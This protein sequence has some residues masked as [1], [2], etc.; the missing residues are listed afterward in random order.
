VKVITSSTASP[1]IWCALSAAP[2]ARAAA[3]TG[4]SLCPQLATTCPQPNSQALDLVRMIEPPSSRA[5]RPTLPGA[6]PALPLPR[7]GGCE[8]RAHHTGTNRAR[9]D[10]RVLPG[11]VHCG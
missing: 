7:A 11:H 4:L 10:Q 2:A 8:A 5:P 6:P 3:T 9:H 1:S